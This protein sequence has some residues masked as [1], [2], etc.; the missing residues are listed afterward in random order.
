MST[1]LMQ[2]ARVALANHPRCHAKSKRSGQQCRNPAMS[3]GVCRMHGGNAGRPPTHGRYTNDVKM[4]NQE[5]KELLSSIY[6]L[7]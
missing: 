3:N 4:L 7:I 1:N 5:V 6:A 2:K